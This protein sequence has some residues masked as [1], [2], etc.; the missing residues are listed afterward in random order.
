[1][2]WFQIQ[3]YIALVSQ[4]RAKDFFLML[5]Y[6]VLPVLTFLSIC[7]SGLLRLCTRGD[8]REILPD[9]SN[10]C[11]HCSVPCPMPRCTICRLPVKG[12]SISFSLS[13]LYLFWLFWQDFRVLVWLVHM[14]LI[15]HVGIRWMLLFPYALP[16]VDA[17]VRGRMVLLHVLLQGSDWHLPFHPHSL[18]LMTSL[19]NITQG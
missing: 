12:T 6:F 10:I 4:S 14:W 18:C 17:F 15:F 5:F 1:M 13:I 3:N 19:R 2:I 9:D 8:C 16:V 11:K 7:C